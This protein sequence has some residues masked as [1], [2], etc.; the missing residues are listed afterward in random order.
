MG[1]SR[2]SAPS[3]DGGW[4]PISGRF[5]PNRGRNALLDAI[6][7]YEGN[8]RTLAGGARSRVARG[9]TPTPPASAGRFTATFLVREYWENAGLS[10]EP[11]K[12]R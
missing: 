7:T 1:L 4:T 12:V 8:P 10:Y 11:P 6:G 5:V 2:M 3:M 9:A